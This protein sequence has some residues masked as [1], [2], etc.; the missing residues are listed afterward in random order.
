[1][2][3]FLNAESSKRTAEEAIKEA[4]ETEGADEGERTASRGF[5]KLRY[6]ESAHIDVI[7]SIR[8][9]N[10]AFSSYGEGVTILRKHQ[11][12]LSTILFRQ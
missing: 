8:R 10:S 11:D 12:I 7:A 5:S 2:R 4:A 3:V 1:M 9:R 6:Q